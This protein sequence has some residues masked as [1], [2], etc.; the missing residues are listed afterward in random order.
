MVMAK[1]AIEQLKALAM[2]LKQQ[3]QPHDNIV[4]T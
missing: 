2:A 3:G 4:R 1:D